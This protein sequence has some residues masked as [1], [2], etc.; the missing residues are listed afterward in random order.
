[1]VYA[2]DIVVNTGEPVMKGPDNYGQG[3]AT[4]YTGSGP[5]WRTKITNWERLGNNSAENP[6]PQ[7]TPDPC[8]QADPSR[9]CYCVT[10]PQDPFVCLT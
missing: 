5:L 2:T 9:V 3:G 7:P 8:R 1:M 10:P 4:L 6:N